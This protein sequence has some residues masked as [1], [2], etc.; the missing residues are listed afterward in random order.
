MKKYIKVLKVT[1]WSVRF[2]RRYNPEYEKENEHIPCECG[3]IYYRHFDGYEEDSSVHCKYCGCSNFI[4]YT[5]VYS[6]EGLELFAEYL[7]SLNI[8]TLTDRINH[9]RLSECLEI[10]DHIRG[11]FVRYRMTYYFDEIELNACI[12]WLKSHD[13]GVKKESTPQVRARFRRG[14]IAK[15][16]TSVKLSYEQKPDNSNEQD[17]WG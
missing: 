4:P 9:D 10:L 12:D 3:H 8:E 7:L 2:H 11:G 14:R 1:P 6:E 17:T 5:E 13:I 15:K 16:P